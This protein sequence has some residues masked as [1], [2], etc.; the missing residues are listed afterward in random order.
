MGLHSRAELENGW[1]DKAC[2]LDD[3]SRV[4]AFILELMSTAGLDLA[5]FYSRLENL[6]YIRMRNASAE[7]T[8]LFEIL[9]QLKDKPSPQKGSTILKEAGQRAND[10]HDAVVGMTFT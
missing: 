4:P 8:V 1:I 6:Y 2:E 9:R 5:A 3:L 7:A 10:V